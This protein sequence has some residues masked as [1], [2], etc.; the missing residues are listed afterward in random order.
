M[1]A[2]HGFEGLADK[3]ARRMQFIVTL[4]NEALGQSGGAFDSEPL[5]EEDWNAVRS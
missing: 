3:I 5:E 2:Y 4:L 1:A